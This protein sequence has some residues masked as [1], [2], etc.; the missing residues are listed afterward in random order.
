VISAHTERHTLQIE[1]V[2]KSA[3]YPK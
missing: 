3:D 1:E 2:K